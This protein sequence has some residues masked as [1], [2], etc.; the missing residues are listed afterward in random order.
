MVIVDP[1]GGATGGEDMFIIA[2]EDRGEVETI[3]ARGTEALSRQHKKRR[4][5]EA[6]LPPFFL[7]SI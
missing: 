3:L 5:I 1:K 4:K 6:G 7:C 2:G